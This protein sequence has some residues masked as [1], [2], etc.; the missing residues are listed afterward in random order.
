MEVVC[1]VVR[2]FSLIG[3]CRCFFWLL[4]GLLVVDAIVAGLFAGLLGFVIC[5]QFWFFGFGLV[6]LF[7]ADG[8]L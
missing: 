7:C 8:G 5:W 3:L 4:V 2:C 6:C 1:G